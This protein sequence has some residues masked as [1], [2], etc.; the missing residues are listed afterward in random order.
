VSYRDSR[1]QQ[2]SAEIKEL[3]DYEAALRRRSRRGNIIKW[4]VFGVLLAV[5]LGSCFGPIVVG[6]GQ[7][8]WRNRK[9]P[10]ASAEQKQVD[11]TLTTIE[12]NARKS[13][14]SFQDMWPKIKGR[15]IGARKDLGRCTVQVPAPELR[16]KDE[17]RSLEDSSMA[18]GWTFIDVTPADAKSPINTLKMPR[19]SVALNNSGYG[20]RYVLPPVGLKTAPP[21]R[22]PTLSSTL[23][24]ERVK[25]LREESKKLRASDQENYLD[26]VKAFGADGMGIDVIV[27][28][29]FWADPKMTNE[30]APTP[31]PPADDLEAF[32]TPTKLPARLFDPGFAVAH[33]IA[34]DPSTQ[35]VACAAQAVAK[36]SEHITFRSDQLEPLQQDL[37]LELERELG[38]QW[39][40]AGDAP[41][42]LEAPVL[43]PRLT[44]SPPTSAS[45]APTPPPTA[46]AKRPTHHLHYGDPCKS[47]LECPSD[48][49]CD[50]QKHCAE[51]PL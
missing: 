35:K 21:D 9:V 39:V 32:N 5:G 29:D 2:S 46:S 3:D 10:L 4:S 30:L 12:A 48:G 17:G 45:A 7:E 18:Y 16:R 51:G 28:V 43:T 27:F 26:R 37:V 36:S 8:E 11:D 49:F 44:T 34:W 50:S 23:L 6:I 22:V 20:D 24:T 40:A 25:E 1:Q 19:G 13:Q 31:P 38:R 42:T 14:S 47:S 41:P 15:E 33:A